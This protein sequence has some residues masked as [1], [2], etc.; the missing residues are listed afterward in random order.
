MTSPPR[1]LCSTGSACSLA[2]KSPGRCTLS[3]R[4]RGQCDLHGYIADPACERG[5]ARLQYLFVNGRWIR[6]R[7]LGH[8]VQEAYRGLL[9]T[10]RYAVSFL[11]L[12][13][14]PDQVDVNVHPTKVEVRFRDSQALHHLVFAAIRDRL[15]Q[16]NL[17]ARLRVTSTLSP[18][19]EDNL[20][21]IPEINR[22]TPPRPCSRQ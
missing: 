16:E 15:R 7:S 14:P 21:P 3:R 17:T 12:D 2:R 5:T 18:S 1:P 10:G 11:F 9:M 22:A 19:A 8:A 20:V 4:S 6:D 13:M